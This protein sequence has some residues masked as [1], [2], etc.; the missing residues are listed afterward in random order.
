MLYDSDQ[1]AIPVAVIFLKALKRTVAAFVLS[2]LQLTA[3]L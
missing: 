3:S 2:T 1:I